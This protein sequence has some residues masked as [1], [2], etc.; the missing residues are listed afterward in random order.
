MDYSFGRWIKHRRKALD[1]MQQELAH[2]VVCFPLAIFK[3]ETDEWYPSRVA[4]NRELP[5][6][7]HTF[8]FK[9]ARTSRTVEADR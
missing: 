7:Q 2:R 3:I 6:S 5:P 1:L 4:V 9:V 8:S